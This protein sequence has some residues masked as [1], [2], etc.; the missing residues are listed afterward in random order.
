MIRTNILMLFLIT[1][2]PL[3]HVLNARI[4]FG[5]IFASDT[6]V[7]SVVCTHGADLD[8]QCTIDDSCFEAPPTYSTIGTRF[9]NVKIQRKKTGLK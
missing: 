2:I 5:N 9:A 6:P 3:F 1:E 7:E 8:M 4:T